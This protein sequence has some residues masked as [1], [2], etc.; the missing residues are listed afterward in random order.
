LESAGWIDSDDN[1][2]RDK[3]INGR[4]EELSFRF[5]ITGSFLS[6]SVSNIVK[7]ACSNAGIEIEIIE[8]PWPPTRSE[9]LVTGDFEML[10]SRR[11]Q[12]P[13]K[14]DPYIYYH[15]S[16]VGKGGANYARYSNPEADKHMELIRTTKD[17]TIRRKAYMDL[18]EVIFED[19][20]VV[21][22][23]SPQLRIIH[24]KDITPVISSKRPGYFVNLDAS[25]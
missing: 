4:K 7:E 18:Q 25:L 13:V 10:V 22:I 9:N 3:V 15:S 24:D 17:E 8:K 1:G 23:Y 20:P 11:T 2:I 16:S 21:F 14:D 12:S 5:H 19:E 6:T